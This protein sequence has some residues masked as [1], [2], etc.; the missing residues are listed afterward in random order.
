M[1]QRLSEWKSLFLALT[2]LLLVGLFV[3]RVMQPDTPPPV[4]EPTVT[5]SA[6]EARAHVG[7]S[8]EVCGAVTEVS[9]A[10]R[11]RGAPTFVNLGEAY[12]AQAFTAV[13]WGD[14]RRHWGDRPPEQRYRDQ[15]ICVR[16]TI[17][18]H[19]GTPQIEVQHPQQIDM[20]PA[21]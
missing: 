4:E 2:A 5:V 10:S 11:I 16:G 1:L 6:G 15:S 8:A 21:R 7:E 12:P 17:A 13:I 18:L 20:R 9:Y 14:A 19:E 3:S